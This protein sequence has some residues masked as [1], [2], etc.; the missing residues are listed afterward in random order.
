MRYLSE[1]EKSLG[2]KIGES[3]LKDPKY[4]VKIVLHGEM[5]APEG[6]EKLKDKVEGLGATWKRQNKTFSA[7]TA[8]YEKLKPFFERPN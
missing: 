4:Y 8:D 7:S 1:V 6:A 2:L 5:Y 3:G